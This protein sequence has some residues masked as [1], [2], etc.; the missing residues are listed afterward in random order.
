MKKQITKEQYVL[1]DMIILSLILIALEIAGKLVLN[2]F[3]RELFTISLVLPITLIAM[4][5]HGAIGSALA[6]IGAVV[7]C[8]LNSASWDVYII[9]IVG[10]LFIVI[11][12][13]W[14]RFWGKELIRISL[15]L[16]VFYVLS[17]YILMNLGRS[18]L[19]F[20]FGYK[21]FF[22]NMVRYFTT[23]ALSGVMAVVILWVA[24]RQ[25]GVF[26]DQMIYLKRIAAEEE[27]RNGK[28]A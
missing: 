2:A 3:P 25:D 12:L 15:L 4:M 13:L 9:Y 6:V 18:V 20:T 22:D 11:N 19:A 26:E 28:K 7:Y 5:R 1:I 8:A 24:R 10:N 23:D 16:V 27:Q 14:F 17:G 21:P